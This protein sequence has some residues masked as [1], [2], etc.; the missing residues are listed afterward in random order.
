MHVLHFQ[1]IVRINMTIKEKTLLQNEV[2]LKACERARDGNGRIH[3]LGLVRQF[4]FF[5]INMRVRDKNDLFF[6]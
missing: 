3:F 1:D 4:S 6:L 5:N 2:F